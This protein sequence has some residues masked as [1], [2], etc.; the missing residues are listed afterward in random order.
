MLTAACYCRYHFGKQGGKY[1]SNNAP[2]LQWVTEVFR[3]SPL[4]APSFTYRCGTLEETDP[5]TPYGVDKRVDE[6]D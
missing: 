3:K 1:K 6:E 4:L 2:I 5:P